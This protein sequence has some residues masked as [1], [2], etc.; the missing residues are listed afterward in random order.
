M[1][2]ACWLATW[3]AGRLNVRRLDGHSA[4]NQA[5]GLRYPS[6]NLQATVREA[7]MLIRQ[8]AGLCSSPLKRACYNREC[9]VVLDPGLCW[10]SQAAN[11]VGPQV[12]IELSGLVDY[13]EVVCRADLHTSRVVVRITHLVD[14]G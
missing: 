6:G 13:I 14:R 9:P 3:Q 10:K 7:D 2:T 5:Q 1:T 11:H 4:N 12:T 8:C